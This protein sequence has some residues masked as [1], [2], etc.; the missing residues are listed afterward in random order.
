M[1]V[2]CSGS[3]KP[4]IPPSSLLG[5]GTRDEMILCMGLP[6]LPY[7]QILKCFELK[8]AC[9]L[10]FFF[11]LEIALLSC[12]FSETISYPGTA[13][14][15]FIHCTCISILGTGR[16]NGIGRKKIHFRDKI[17]PLLCYS[18]SPGN[19]NFLLSVSITLDILRLEFCCFCSL[20]SFQACARTLGCRFTLFASV[21]LLP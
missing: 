2:L 15:L 9:S 1:C 13:L 17:V 10:A 18:C 8:K 11:F 3:I 5:D 14:I 12:S 7:I 20:F 4:L 16:R 19:T 6:L 21:I